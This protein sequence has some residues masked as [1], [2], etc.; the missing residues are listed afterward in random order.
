MTTKKKLTSTEEDSTVNTNTLQKTLSES[1]IPC[2][3]DFH[4]DWCGPCKIMNPVIEAL[5]QEYQN[6][7]CVIKINVD[8]NA[9]LAKEYRVRAIPTFVFFVGGVEI[10]RMVGASPTELRHRIATNVHS[11]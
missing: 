2:L 9:D 4:A 8:N 11:S 10:W 1:G 3:V 5:T 7:L 6:R